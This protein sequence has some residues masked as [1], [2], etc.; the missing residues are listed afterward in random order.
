MEI[1]SPKPTGSAVLSAF[2]TFAFDP[3]YD[4]KRERRRR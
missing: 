4:Y 1:F 3:G 2:G